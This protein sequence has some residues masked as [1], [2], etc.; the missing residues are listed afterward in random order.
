VPH[1]VDVHVGK[2]LRGLRVS[3]GLS[4]T[5]LGKALG[6][7]FQQVQKYENGSNRVSASKLYDISQFLG[8]PLSY[9]F[10]GLPGQRDDELELPVS[11]KAARMARLYEL[12]PDDSFK[13]HLYVLVRSAVKKR[14]DNSA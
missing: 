1:Q 10:H 3:K 14:A 7:S 6:L 13:T 5:D 12:L 9:F 8:V 11:L 2:Q 4:Q